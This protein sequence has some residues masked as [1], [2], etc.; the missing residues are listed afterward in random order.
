MS[1]AKKA[2]EKKVME[3]LKEK[4]KIRLKTSSK[5]NKKNKKITELEAKIKNQNLLIKSLQNEN[6]K[7]KK[8][9]EENF[10]NYINIARE[11]IKLL[12]N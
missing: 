4:N 3:F 7:A 11:K 10:T 2:T 1:L 12:K 6:S 5:T 9:F 8:I